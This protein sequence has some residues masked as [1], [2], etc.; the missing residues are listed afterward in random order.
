MTCG[1]AFKRLD[2]VTSDKGYQGTVVVCSVRFLPVAG[3]VPERPVIRYVMGLTD[4]E[5]WL[6]PIAGTRVMVPYRMQSP[7]P[8]AALSWCVQ[9]TEFISIPQAARASANGVNGLGR[10]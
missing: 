10:R 2:K 3:Y 8:I 6:A 7:T 4:I 9:A 1:C 5:A